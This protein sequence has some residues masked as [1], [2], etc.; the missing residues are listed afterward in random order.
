MF[1]YSFGKNNVF[2]IHIQLFFLPCFSM[3]S[4]TAFDQA[5]LSCIGRC[6]NVKLN[7]V[8]LCLVKKLKE[9]LTQFYIYNSNKKMNKN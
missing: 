8:K 4:G 2:V 3:I 6:E 5:M 9:V 1:L 7:T